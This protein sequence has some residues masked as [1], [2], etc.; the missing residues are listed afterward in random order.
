MGSVPECASMQIR[1]ADYGKAHSDLVLI[2]NRVSF[3]SVLN[4]NIFLKEWIQHIH[5]TCNVQTDLDMQGC[6]CDGL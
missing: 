6:I 5:L 2:V 3:V 1:L 4:C